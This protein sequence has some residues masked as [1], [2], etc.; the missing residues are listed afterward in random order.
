[1]QRS[2]ARIR[3]LR[4]WGV[5]ALILAA[6]SFTWPDLL[7]W[8]KGQFPGKTKW[9]YLEKVIIPIAPPL[10]IAFG[11]WYLDNGAKNREKIRQEEDSKD[12][13]FRDYLD[14]VSTIL[15]DKDVLSLA[16]A[17]GP[18]NPI[19]ETATDVIRA[20]TL[21]ILGSFVDDIKKKS[22]VIHFL[23]ETDALSAL[24][25]SLSGALLN[26]ANLFRCHLANADLNRADLRRA[27]LTRAD[28]S[29][30]NLYRADLS[31]A[32]ID[33]AVLTKTTLN[34][35]QLNKARLNHADLGEAILDGACLEGASLQNA[36]LQR[37]ELVGAQLDKADF[38]NA[39]LTGANLRWSDLNA[40]I[41]NDDTKWPERGNFEGAKHI[42]K[43]LKQ[44]LG[45]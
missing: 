15:I 45:H 4:W 10:A 19:V 28:L 1:M 11:V 14:R 25:V 3:R 22:S 12:Q 43:A 32:T 23:I 27:N 40:I 2:I 41:W 18:P 34:N 42:P 24:K 39:D 8:L 38:R 31:E 35:A 44:K 7:V 36:N 9:D 33:G 20:R 30:S 5:L 13:A 6:I 29:E 26:E 21:S 16:K 17:A 37:A